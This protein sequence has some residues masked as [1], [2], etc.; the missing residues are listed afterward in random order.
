VITERGTV[1]GFGNK[2]K[3]G[4]KSTGAVKTNSAKNDAF[5]KFLNGFVQICL[6]RGLLK[7]GFDSLPLFEFQAQLDEH[8]S[9]QRYVSSHD[10]W[11]IGVDS[12]EY[13]FT[14]EQARFYRLAK[15]QLFMALDKF[16]IKDVLSKSAFK[17][18][19]HMS[20]Q[21]KDFG[22]I[23][24]PDN[25]KYLNSKSVG[26]VFLVDLLELVLKYREVP[27]CM[28]D[29]K[30]KEKTKQCM[31]I[32]I[33]DMELDPLREPYLSEEGSELVYKAD[34]YS[35]LINLH[36]SGAFHFEV[37]FNCPTVTRTRGHV[38][39]MDGFYFIE[40]TLLLPIN[41]FS[42]DESDLRLFLNCLSKYAVVC[43]ADVIQAMRDS[44][45]KVTA[46]S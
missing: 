5:E 42:M 44:R 38:Y 13:D 7:S 32:V 4:I 28:P 11:L 43:S 24:L 26:I 8:V 9:R 37:K 23:T 33:K 3:T 40:R 34:K 12:N 46:L 19:G 18:V 1:F 22:I 27:L 25:I 41:I 39:P 10:N 36:S 35:I 17:Q 2:K 15:Y 31:E 30:S 14:N 20:K 45:P 21:R 6:G 16:L 29:E